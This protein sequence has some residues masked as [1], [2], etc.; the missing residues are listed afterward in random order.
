MDQNVGP[1]A[2]FGLFGGALR[3]DGATFRRAA[4]D[5][6]TTRLCIVVASLAALA[7]GFSYGA[8]AA[9]G[10]LLD[11]RD[12]GLHRLLIA[13]GAAETVVHLLLF[14]GVTV[15]LRL[16]A[17]D[18]RAKF[19]I[20]GRPLALALAPA[21]FVFLGALFDAPGV[22]RPLV[23]LW[24]FA[25]CVV[26]LRAVAETSWLGAVV[27]VLVADVVAAPLASV[28]LFG[29]AGRP[30]VPELPGP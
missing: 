9:S 14:I 8:E 4:D 21:C 28:V 25:A 26:A 5:P 29:V 2:L 15:L 7:N 11:E 1:G 27:T 22:V 3:L 18:P 17:R 23:A 20:F 19:E 24:R 10:H 13:V 30:M 6:G 12:F 16:F